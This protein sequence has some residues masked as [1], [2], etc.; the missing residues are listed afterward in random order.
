VVD[1]GRVARTVETQIAQVNHEIRSGRGDVAD[2]GSP[3]LL[4][5][6]G[7]RREMSV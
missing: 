6:W 4:G 3:V 2:D 5:F 7:I 1:V